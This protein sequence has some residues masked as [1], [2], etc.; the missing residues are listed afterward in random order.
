MGPQH[1]INEK[2]LRL[3]AVVESSYRHRYFYLQKNTP[4]WV[5]NKKLTKNSWGMLKIT[6]I[7]TKNSLN[8]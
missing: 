6:L 2:V 3:K 4:H 1:K 5:H 7:F 8:S